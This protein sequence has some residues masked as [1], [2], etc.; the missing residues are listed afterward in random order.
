[1]TTCTWAQYQDDDYESHHD[2][3]CDNRFYEDE[4]NAVAG[5]TYCPWCGE[6]II[7]IPGD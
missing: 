3:Q 1:M 5:F 4:N 7:L 6:E 2:T